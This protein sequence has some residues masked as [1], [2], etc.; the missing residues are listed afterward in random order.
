MRRRPIAIAVAL[1]AAVTC[2]CAAAAGTRGPASAASGAQHHW[3]RF[4]HAS[5]PID[6]AGPRPDGSLILAAN[7]R[8][9]VLEPSGAVRPFAPAYQAPPGEAYIDMFLPVGKHAACFG[10]GTVYALQLGGQS[11]VVGIRPG[12][13][14][15]QLATIPHSGLLS[16]IAFDRTGR[17]GY[18]LLVTQTSSTTSS[19]YAIDCH[20]RVGTITTTAPHIEG[21]VLVAPRTF[22]RFA[23][24]LIASDELGG[25]I[26]AITPRG[27]SILVAH[28]GLPHGG[29]IGVESEGFVPAAKRFAMLVSDRLTPGNPHPG[30]NLILRIRSA[31]LHA[32]GAR[33]G[34]MIVVSEGAGT[35]DVVHCS[36]Q[37][38]QARVIA[39]GPA[40]AH[41]EGHVAVLP[42]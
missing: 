32:A 20:G 30:D 37:S 21:G 10:P 39:Q 14:P 2:G 13:K 8:L 34:D 11:G 15:R 41:I 7:R 23:G 28:S 42:R 33:A 35:T 12:G 38:C 5:M 40:I 24:D 9:W 6:L 16:G 1:L 36:A 4:L 22:G 25:N 3:A 18:R 27:G 26:Y 29:D 17:F 19:V 31:A